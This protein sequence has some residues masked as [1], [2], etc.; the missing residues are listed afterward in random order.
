MKEVLLYM[1]IKNGFIFN[2][3]TVSFEKKDIRI[4]EGIITG[5][6]DFSEGDGEYF[7]ADGAYI[8]P[9]L[10]DIHTHGRE[11]A[12]FVSCDEKD[13]HRVAGEYA[14]R[15]VSCVMPTLASAPFE[16][17]LDAVDKINRFVP[18]DG[19]AELCGVHIEGRYLNP[20]KGGAHARELLQP[21]D[22]KELDAKEF[23]ACRALHITAAFELDE[24]ASFI[25]KINE[26]GATASLGHTMANYDEAKRAEANGLVAYTHLFNT[27]P[28][29]NHRD[30][31]AVCAALEGKAFAELICDGIHI[32][33]EMIRLA[34]RSLG[35]ERTV[36]VS[37][38][39]EATGLCDGEYS[40]AG[41]PAYVVNGIAR[42]PDGALAGSTLELFEGVKNLMRFCEIPFEHALICATANPAKTVGIY[43]KHGSLEIGKYADMMLIRDIYEPKADKIFI[44]GRLI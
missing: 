20:K 21:L 10:V 31:G 44:R 24:D 9:A 8:V 33:P 25:R 1:L 41:M 6:G 16:H 12:D 39:I 29:L 2:S 22:A 11:G 15:G 5:F 19:E 34:Y 4:E 37:D 42:T 27:M 7:D 13:L 38:S 43:D 36:L 40:I 35:Y 14:K 32:S 30:G 23:S 18:A 26:I 17:M 3:N 28:P